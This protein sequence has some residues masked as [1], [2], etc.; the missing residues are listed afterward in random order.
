MK[1]LSSPTWTKKLIFDFSE[2]SRAYRV[3][4]IPINRS[5]NI[6]EKHTTT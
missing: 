5:L 6:E 3:L 2:I 4:I 1:E